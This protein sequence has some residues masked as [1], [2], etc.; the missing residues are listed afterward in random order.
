MDES[1]EKWKKIPEGTH[2]VIDG[3]DM[4]RHNG[5]WVSAQNVKPE[6]SELEVR[7]GENGKEYRRRGDKD[8]KPADGSQAGMVAQDMDVNTFNSER[9]AGVTKPRYQEEK[10]PKRNVKPI[11]GSVSK[12]WDYDSP[13]DYIKAYAFQRP[14][15]KAGRFLFST[16]NTVNWLVSWYQNNK[17]I[18]DSPEKQA[19]DKGFEDAMRNFNNWCG[20]IDPKTDVDKVSSKELNEIYTNLEFKLDEME[21]AYQKAR[22]KTDPESLRI[23]TEYRLYQK[24]YRNMKDEIEN[25]GSGNKTED[26]KAKIQQ[27]RQKKMLS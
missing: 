14:K 19:V 27:L 4:I 8:W 2:R 24:M 12:P 16:I 9:L 17:D 10:K 3:K 1:V 26:A 7:Q 23:K 18:P 20:G 15:T 22:G 13:M 21:S 25:R 5:K 6:M 11:G